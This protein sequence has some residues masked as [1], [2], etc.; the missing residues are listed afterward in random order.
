MN[1]PS[2]SQLEILQ[3]LWEHEPATVRFIHEQ[4][5]KLKDVQYTTTLKQIQRMTEKGMV[6]AK[7]QGRSYTYTTIIKEHQVKKSLI[8]R[9]VDGAFKGSAIELALHALGQ[10]KPTE[11]ELD[12]L[13]DWLEEQKNK[14]NK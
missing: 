2:E 6:K 11:D 1:Q 5:A 10:S 3:I 8:N 4:L 13:K 7:K 12:R 9:L 14:D